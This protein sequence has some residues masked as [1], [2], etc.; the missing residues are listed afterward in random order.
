MSVGVVFLLT[1]FKSLML[2]TTALLGLLNLLMV[3][4]YCLGIVTMV[5]VEVN[6]FLH[7]D[8]DQRPARAPGG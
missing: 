2:A 8:I 4:F 1:V 6:S 5:G 3:Y 7:R